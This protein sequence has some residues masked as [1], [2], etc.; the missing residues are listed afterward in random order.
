MGPQGFSPT[1]RPVRVWHTPVHAQ[2]ALIQSRE[3]DVCC[4]ERP[5]APAAPCGLY[6]AALRPTGTGGERCVNGF[7]NHVQPYLM[8]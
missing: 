6:A 1:A 3:Q 8:F 4:G 5:A 7:D 2:R